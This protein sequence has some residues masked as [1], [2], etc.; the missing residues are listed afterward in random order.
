[1]LT[2]F[3][4]IT[5]ANSQTFKN[6]IKGR[7]LEY[8]T[9]KPL[10]FV[11][12][13]ISGT[14][15]G[16]T[17]DQFGNFEIKG[18]PSG[19][20]EIV[21]SIIGYDSQTKSVHLID[22][23]IVQVIF[24]LNEAHYELEAV[25]ISGEVPITWKNN[26]A[27]FEK[28]FLGNS[29]FAAD[30]TIK[31]PEV[32]NFKWTNSH[33]LTAQA[34]EPLTIINNDLGYLINCVL[35]SFDWDAETYQVQ[36]TLRPSYT[37]MKDTSGTKKDEWENN[38]RIAYKG[39]LDNFLEGV[40]D[41]KLN[42]DGFQVY[43]DYGPLS[44]MSLKSLSRIWEPL[45]KSSNGQYSLSFSGYLRILYVSKDPDKPQVSWLKLLYPTITLDKYGYP[46][47]PLPFEVYGYWTESGMADMLPKYYSPGD[48]L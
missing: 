35:V 1:M 9:G 36:A 34:E 38:R 24:K 29:K 18:L 12:V 10:E 40:K 46:I 37:E 30:C 2:A 13:Y 26:Y 14:T 43:Q 28:R 11:N 48:S 6:S 5:V 42:V 31:N 4:L 39:S 22:G 15:W 27:L 33:H 16:T 7:V 45:S 25:T 3:L 19:Y 20:Q 21:A 17:T 23:N 44:D 32:I 8:D 41:N 47:E